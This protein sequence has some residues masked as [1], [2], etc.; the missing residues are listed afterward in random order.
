MDIK[1]ALLFFNTYKR[2]S[3]T[4]IVKETNKDGYIKR[5]AMVCRFVNYYNIKTV[6]EANKNRRGKISSKSMAKT[7]NKSKV[8][9]K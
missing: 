6:K 2:G 3:Y 1:S 5:V 4:R 9:K 8:N 7:N